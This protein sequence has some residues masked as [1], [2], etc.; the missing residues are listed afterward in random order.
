MARSA[1]AKETPPGGETPKSAACAIVDA[2]P[3]P[4][5]SQRSL[6]SGGP[7]CRRSSS[8]ARL[9]GL[10]VV[11]LLDIVRR[12]S[13]AEEQG[14]EFP[15][16]GQRCILMLLTGRPVREG[17]KAQLLVPSNVGTAYKRLAYIRHYRTTLPARQLRAVSLEG[18][19]AFANNL[20]RVPSGIG[21][22]HK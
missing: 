9:D 7:C 15:R 14:S 5:P 18:G 6:H 20:S 2:E 22:A 3:G 10:I 16:T 4:R 8:A 21:R 1:P 11:R 12:D 13:T 17:S 19:L